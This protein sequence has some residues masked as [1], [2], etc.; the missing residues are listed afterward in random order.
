MIPWCSI[1]QFEVKKYQRQRNIDHLRHF[2][3]QANNKSSP[4]TALIYVI[5]PEGGSIE[6][7][8]HFFLAALA[9]EATTI[10]IVV[11]GHVNDEA[12]E[13]LSQYSQVLYRDN[14]GYDVA[15]FRAGILALN[16]DLPSLDRLI[17]ANDSS[18]GPLYD[19]H[20]IMRKMT[21]RDVDF[22]GLLYGPSDIDP[23]E[24]CPYGY[25]AKHLQSYFTVIEKT[26]LQDERFFDYWYKQPKANN[27]QEAI[28]IH[29]GYFTKY[30]EDLGYRSKSYIHKKRY[31]D[32]YAYPLTLLRDYHFPII[33]K[34]A[35]D[36]DTDAKLQM[37]R[38]CRAKSEVQELLQ[39][40][41][42]EEAVDIL[43]REEIERI[44][45]QERT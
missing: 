35:L 16:E 2:H 13:Y 36:Y 5:Y 3:Q 32:P 9:K 25:L 39:F 33:K 42:H 38:G 17:L 30:F 34:A 44:V 27:R 1:K 7:Y 8:K 31:S 23:T 6:R 11:N 12:K 19:I 22:W 15:G 10:Q 14:Q 37:I 24:L 20:E 26:L 18:I 4:T 21:Q 43:L 40:I 41:K 29:E 28:A 45:K